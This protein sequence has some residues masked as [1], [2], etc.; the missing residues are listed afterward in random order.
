M[1]DKKIALFAIGYLILDYLLFA[2]IT[3]EFNSMLWEQEIKAGFVFMIMTL[4][5]AVPFYRLMREK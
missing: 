4:F 3:L 1:S 5:P 2:L